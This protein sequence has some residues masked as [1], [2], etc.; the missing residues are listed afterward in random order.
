M[1]CPKCKQE[2]RLIPAGVSK[3]SGKTYKAFYSCQA[4]HIT[5]NADGSIGKAPTTSAQSGN[6]GNGEVMKALREIYKLLELGIER[7]EKKIDLLSNNDSL[8]ITKE[9]LDIFKEE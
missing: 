2:F 6:S 4:C 1:N 3:T 8:D 9:D 5:A 7:L